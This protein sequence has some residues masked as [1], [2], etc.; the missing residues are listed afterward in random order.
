MYRCRSHGSGSLSVTL[1][2]CLC[3]F[4]TSWSRYI[5]CHAYHTYD[6]ILSW[7]TALHYPLSSRCAA[8]SQEGNEKSRVSRACLYSSPLRWFRRLS[9]FQEADILCA[10]RM[11]AAFIKWVQFALVA[12][13]AAC[14]SRLLQLQH[15]WI[16]ELSLP[17]RGLGR[18]EV[19][20]I[21]QEPGG[22]VTPG[23]FASQTLTSFRIS[24]R[25]DWPT[26]SAGTLTKL[27]RSLMWS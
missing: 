13:L 12:E 26:S 15:C 2:R 25:A 21:A 11:E 18:P 10:R 23:S 7:G 3:A 24:P 20:I 1:H 8:A 14:V 17:G 19:W 9:V 22:K 4:L 27:V 5:Q 16:R 6:H